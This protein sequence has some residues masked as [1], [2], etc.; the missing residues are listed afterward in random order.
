[1]AEDGT[2]PHQRFR[3]GLFAR[4]HANDEES[5]DQTEKPPTSTW[6]MGMLNDR[7]TIEVPGRFSRIPLVSFA[8][9]VLNDKCRLGFASCQ[10]PE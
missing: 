8:N 1:M 6:N 5:A 9:R 4:K 3:R 10:R 7:E 2:I